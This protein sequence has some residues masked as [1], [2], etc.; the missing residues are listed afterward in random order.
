MPR[1]E[2]VVV[3]AGYN[4]N[5]NSNTASPLQLKFKLAFI[6]QRCGVQ[7]TMDNSSSKKI[8]SVFQHPCH[9][10]VSIIRVEQQHE[11]RIELERLET[12]DFIFPCFTVEVK[13]QHV[14][15]WIVH[16][17]Q[18]LNRRCR[19]VGA[20]RVAWAKNATQ[21]DDCLVYYYQV[22]ASSA[23]LVRDGR[24]QLITLEGCMMKMTENTKRVLMESMGEGGG[25]TDDGEERAVVAF[26]RHMLPSIIM[27]AGV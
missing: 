3:V 7:K 21:K 1:A 27:H 22:D 8:V 12:D 9:G 17:L 23:A 13:M 20:G 19:S 11:W 15:A 14:L 5:K 25:S 16:T 4:N 10:A 18:S 26:A 24:M 6:H 2:V